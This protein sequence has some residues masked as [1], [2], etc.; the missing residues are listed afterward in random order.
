MTRFNRTL[1]EV[2]HK[3]MSKVK[4]GKRLKPW[5]TLTVKA[6]IK[7]RNRLRKEVQSNREEWVAACQ[8]SAKLVKEAKEP[9]GLTLSSA[10]NQTQTRARY[11]I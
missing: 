9:S 6:A 8:K 10:W 7:R 2:A 5:L 3:T 4:Q 1:T 11:G